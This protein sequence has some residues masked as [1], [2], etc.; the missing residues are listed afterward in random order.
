MTTAKIDANRVPTLLAVSSSDGSTLLNVKANPVN[1]A[2]KAENN[3]TGS[4][5]GSPVNDPRDENRKVAFWAVSA[6]DGV[7][8]V[9]VYVDSNG[10]LLINSN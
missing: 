5:L 3:T 1:N 6:V 4:D 8:P 2:M 9:A 10:Q 7:T